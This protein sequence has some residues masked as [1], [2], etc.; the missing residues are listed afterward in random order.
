MAW[1]GRPQHFLPTSFNLLDLAA[2]Q[3]KDEL[4]I[5]GKL[6]TPKG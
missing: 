1:A 6:T 3:I 4:V 5:V 2:L